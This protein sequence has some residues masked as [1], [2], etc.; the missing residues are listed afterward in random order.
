MLKNSFII[1][2]KEL[3]LFTCHLLLKKDF[4]KTPPKYFA[5]LDPKVPDFIV[6]KI[7]AIYRTGL[8]PLHSLLL[9]VVKDKIM[10]RRG[11]VW[12]TQD[13][14]S[15]FSRYATCSVVEQPLMTSEVSLPQAKVVQSL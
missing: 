6:A 15:A 14:V 1:F 9:V 12:E 2:I 10:G 13:L 4:I 11:P 5:T 3:V 7:K 8:P